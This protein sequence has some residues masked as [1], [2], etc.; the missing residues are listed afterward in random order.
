[1]LNFKHVTWLQ[2]SVR[3]L[4]H[5][6]RHLF[7]C[8]AGSKQERS[9]FCRIACLM[10]FISSSHWKNSLVDIC[11]RSGKRKSV[12]VSSDYGEIQLFK[13]YCRG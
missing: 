10:C 11:L 13:S 2:D 3:L 9:A 4:V 7:K 5:N 6:I 1:M 12:L 8:F